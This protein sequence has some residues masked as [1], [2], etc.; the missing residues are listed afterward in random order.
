MN[1]HKVTQRCSE[2]YAVFPVIAKVVIKSGQT[3]RVEY[4]RTQKFGYILLSDSVA[5]CLGTSLEFLDQ[6][7]VYEDAFTA[8]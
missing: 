4:R 1:P 5:V 6:L 3:Q 8:R 2:F 7:H